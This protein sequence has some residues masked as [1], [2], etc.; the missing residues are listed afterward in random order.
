MRI[1]SNFSVEMYKMEGKAR[2]ALIEKKKKRVECLLWLNIQTK[3]FKEKNSSAAMQPDSRNSHVFSW[4]PN[5]K[6]LHID[7]TD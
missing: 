1:Q 7:A 4:L 5:F 2:C 3:K 6:S